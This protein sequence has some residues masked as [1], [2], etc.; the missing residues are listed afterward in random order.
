MAA[1][2]QPK[3]LKKYSEELRAECIQEYI[4]GQNQEDIAHRHN[5][6]RS[7]IGVWIR[8]TEKNGEADC[9]AKARAERTANFITRS[10]NAVDLL[11]ELILKQTKT[12]LENQDELQQ[13]LDLLQKEDMSQTERQRLARKIGNI[14][15]PGMRDLAIALGTIYDK[16]ALASGEATSINADLNSS[17]DTDEIRSLIDEF[18]AD[19]AAT[20]RIQRV[21]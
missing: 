18:R 6:P 17:V 8:E 11:L 20:A 13:A 12:A 10:K 1:R 7:T 2:K 5:V 14:A 15:A 9:I 19:R 4:Q 21:V 16:G 3:D